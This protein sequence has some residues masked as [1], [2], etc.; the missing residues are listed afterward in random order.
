MIGLPQPSYLIVDL[1][2]RCN[3]RCS[4]CG[5]W[6]WMR[7]ADRVEDLSL[8]EITRVFGKLKFVPQVSLGGG[9]PLLREDLSDILRVVCGTTRVPFLTLG[10]NGSM[11]DRLQRVLGS[12]LGDFPRTTFI[13]NLSVDGVGDLHDRLRG[14]PGLFEKALESADRLRALKAKHPNLKVYVNAV[15]QAANADYLEEWFTFFSRPEYLP[16]SLSLSLVRG[17]V[18]DERVKEVPVE[19][20][21]EIFRRIDRAPVLAGNLRGL[22]RRAVMNAANNSIQ[23]ILQ[24]ERALLPCQAGRYTV[25]VQADGIVIGCPILP[26]RV[27]GGLRESDYDLRAVLNSSRARAFRKRIH[28]ERCYCTW[29]CAVRTNLVFNLRGWPRVLRSLLISL[30]EEARGGRAGPDTPS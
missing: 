15:L 25:E 14:V 1:T 6:S 5:S 24:E 3:A 11:P 2:S 16:D 28:K 17:D 21:R 22:L 19:T 20:I 8:D 23:T 7:N 29:E 13:V 12:V 9:E 26:D 10:T 18:P 30:S 4:F 27:L